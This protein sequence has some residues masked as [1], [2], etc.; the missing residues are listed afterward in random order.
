[1]Y[2]NPN[3]VV[4]NLVQEPP[5]KTPGFHVGNQ[6]LVFLVIQLLSLLLCVT[7]P[8]VKSHAE[9]QQHQRVKQGII[10]FTHIPTLKL[11]FQ[12]TLLLH[13]PASW[14]I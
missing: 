1:M 7:L 14:Q 5:N 6:V 11:L 4:Q 9:K 3:C 2:Y 12:G 13:Y 8:C 10:T